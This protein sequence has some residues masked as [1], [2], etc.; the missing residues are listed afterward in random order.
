M[1]RIVELFNLNPLT[2][3]FALIDV[4]LMAVIVYFFVI[5]KVKKIMLAR[6]AKA[7]EVFKENQRLAQ[8]AADNK[9]KYETLNRE[10]A[11]KLAAAA[12]AAEKAA[13]A[14]AQQVL[15]EAKKQAAGIIAAAKRETD[16]E[17]L[18][19][20]QY[21][22]EHIA[23]IAVDMAAKVLERE[24]REKDNGKI[25]DECLSKWTS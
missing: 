18:R 14:N 12:K 23:S 4:V 8:E 22:R 9:Q 10:A 5:K 1:N 6:N 7:E 11:E 16:A 13:A 2:M 20:E 15:D 3:L 25:L 24:V 21:F 19:M 17:R